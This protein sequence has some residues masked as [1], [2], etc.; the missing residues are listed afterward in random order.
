M[1]Y[2]RIDIIKWKDYE[3]FYHESYEVRTLR[4][5]RPMVTRCFSSMTQAN[6]HARRELARLKKEGYENAVYNSMMID[7]KRFIH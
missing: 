7:L 4:P 3:P 5:K 6:T 1:R 2:P